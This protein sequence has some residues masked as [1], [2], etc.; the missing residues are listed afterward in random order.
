MYTVLRKLST[1]YALD[2]TSR[3]VG[4]FLPIFKSYTRD[5]R[6]AWQEDE[7][8]KFQQEPTVTSFHQYGNPFRRPS[9]DFSDGER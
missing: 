7:D 5:L 9:M 3:D 8:E 1:T 6:V 4:F 2:D